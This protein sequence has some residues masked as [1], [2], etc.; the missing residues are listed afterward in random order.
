MILAVSKARFHWAKT[1]SGG[2]HFGPL[3]VTSQSDNRPG[4]A[5]FALELCLPNNAVVGGLL[6]S[7]KRGEIAAAGPGDGESLSFKPWL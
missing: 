2:E 6:C 3:I 7:K 1:Q 5:S 4:Q